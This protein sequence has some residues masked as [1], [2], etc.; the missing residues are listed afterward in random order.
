LPIDPRSYYSNPVVAKEVCEFLKGRW[1]GV[2]GYEKR[3][4][5]WLG[6]RP[7]T[8]SSPRDVL[9]TIDRFWM[10]SPRSFYG[11]IEIYRKLESRDDVE[12]NYWSNVVAATPFIDIDIVDESRVAE[13]YSHVIRVVEALYSEL[14]V[15]RGVCSSVY[16]LWTGAG[17][18]FRFNERGFREVYSEYHPLK[19]AYAVVE[20]LIRSTRSKLERII[21]ES[22]G[23]VKVENIIAPKRV[24]SAPLSL[25]RTLDRAVIAFKPEEA[26][27]F[28]LEWADPTKPRHDPEAWRRFKAG[29][30]DDYA[31]EALKKLG[32]LIERTTIEHTALGSSAEAL[33]EAEAG[34][35]SSESEPREPG[36]FQVMA[37]LQAVRYYLL[38]G[39]LERAKSWGLNRAIFYAWA[40]YYGPAKQSLIRQK[41]RSYSVKLREVDSGDVEWEEVGGEKA[42][43]SRNGWYVIGGVEQHPEDFDY[44]IARKFEEAGIDFKLAWEKALEYVKRFP[45]GILL[46]P[47]EFYKQ[48]Y[49]PVRDAFVSKVLKYGTEKSGGTDLTKWLKLRNQKQ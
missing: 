6:E 27:E 44:H 20:Y 12:S 49:E 17:A 22:G 10:I 3:W 11:S 33:K 16:V 30:L 34:A 24:F 48:V 19:V 4:V 32:D 25:H 1:A 9:L 7:L 40:K 39:D 45:R 46:N 23:L 42:M 13:A 26:G 18:H 43:V 5:R 37:L 47:Q 2:E 28:T 21:G 15:D 8:I 14:C 41:A 38:T 36:R 35:S 29:E 31:R